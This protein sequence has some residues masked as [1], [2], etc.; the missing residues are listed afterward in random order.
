MSLNPLLC[1]ELDKPM[2]L[3]AFPALLNS[4]QGKFIQRAQ[5]VFEIEGVG[6]LD[7]KEELRNPLAIQHSY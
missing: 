2:Y 3:E 4:D 6:V 1:C 7:V 5:C